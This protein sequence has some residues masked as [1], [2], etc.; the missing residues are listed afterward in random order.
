MRSN[1][2]THYSIDKRRKTLRLARV[3]T[4]EITE[5]ES[6]LLTCDGKGKEAKRAALERLL[7]LNRPPAFGTF[8]YR[9][10]SFDGEF[11]LVRAFWPKTAGEMSGFGFSVVKIEG[12]L[13][14]GFWPKLGRAVMRGASNL[15][16]AADILAR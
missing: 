11:R 1:G 16:S 4:P 14:S 5:L 15:Q 9:V 2:K 3:K 10:H 12:P 6:I 8:L 7:E 13:G